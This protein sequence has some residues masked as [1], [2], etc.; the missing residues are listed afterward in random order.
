MP[1]EQSLFEQ[2]GGQPTLER[3]HKIF[4]DEAYKHSWLKQYF[5]NVDQDLIERQQTDFMAAAMG[6]PRRYSG[7]T[8]PSAHK[9][10]YATQ[11]LFDIRHRMLEESIIKAGVPADLR[12]RWLL[13]DAAFVKGVVKAKVSDCT[14]RYHDEPVL[15]FNKPSNS[16]HEQR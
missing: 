8:V 9:H 3:V 1:T 2:L 14:Q 12:E 15:A 7:K 10:I 11:E 4:Y 5:G 6:G 13:I 16:L